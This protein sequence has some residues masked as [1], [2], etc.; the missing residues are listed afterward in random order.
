[1]GKQISFCRIKPNIY[2]IE[3]MLN[4]LLFVLCKEHDIF[5]CQIHDFIPAINDFINDDQYVNGITNHLILP[6]YSLYSNR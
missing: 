5:N 6:V 2:D 1:M 3:S 4:Y